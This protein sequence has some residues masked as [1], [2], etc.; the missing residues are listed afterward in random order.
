MTINKDFQCTL[1]VRFVK[2]E[3]EVVQEMRYIDGPDRPQIRFLKPKFYKAVK[4]LNVNTEKAKQT[5]QIPNFH[6]KYA[7]FTV[8]KKHVF[9]AARQSAAFS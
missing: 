1:H 5:K 7:Q 4:K 6:S 8:A 9:S 2:E 3:L